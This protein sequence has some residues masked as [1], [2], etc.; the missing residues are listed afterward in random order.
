MKTIVLLMAVFSFFYSVLLVQLAARS[1]HVLGLTRK[2]AFAC[3]SMVL[4]LLFV[5]GKHMLYIGCGVV[6]R[7]RAAP[8][9]RFL[10]G[11]KRRPRTPTVQHVF[12]HGN[13]FFFCRFFRLRAKKP[14][15]GKNPELKVRRAP[16]ASRPGVRP[17]T[18][19]APRAHAGH[20]PSEGRCCRRRRFARSARSR[21]APR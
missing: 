8:P 21:R 1:Q 6:R 17:G 2:A 12:A 5:L 7:S 18:R 11:R 4:F 13:F 15:K 19:P 3:G 10:R 14:T 9:Q 20:R 16:A